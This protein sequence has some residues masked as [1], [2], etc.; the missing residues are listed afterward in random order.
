MRIDGI[1]PFQSRRQD[2]ISGSQSS[3][4]NTELLLADHTVR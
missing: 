1:E 4:S 3:V 2:Q